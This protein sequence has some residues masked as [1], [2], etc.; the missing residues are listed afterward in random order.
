MMLHANL[1]GPP[2]IE[3]PW[4]QHL[5]ADD[6]W[7]ARDVPWIARLLTDGYRLYR[8]SCLNGW[9]TYRVVGRDLLQGR[10][11]LELVVWGPKPRPELWECRD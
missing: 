3:L 8:F 9:A 4:Q 10:T 6:E 5:V 11:V 1:Y 2:S 7:L